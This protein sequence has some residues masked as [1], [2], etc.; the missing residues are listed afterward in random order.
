MRMVDDA[1]M[2]EEEEMNDP[3]EQLIMDKEVKELHTWW[4]K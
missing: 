2:Q 4:C 3:N 1:M